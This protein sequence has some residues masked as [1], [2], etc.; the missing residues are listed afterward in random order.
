MLFLM[1]F[2]IIR[3]NFVINDLLY[4]QIKFCQGC[5]LTWEFCGQELC[6]P[7]KQDHWHDDYNRE[8]DNDE[9]NED[10]AEDD[11]D[12][13]PSQKDPTQVSKLR[14]LHGPT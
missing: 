12:E 6:P 10:D 9:D 8:E 4:D 11:E 1:I 5:S 7:A 3:S 13:L 14:Y 2:S